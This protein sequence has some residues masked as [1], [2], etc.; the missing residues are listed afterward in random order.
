Y[1]RPPVRLYRVRSTVPRLRFVTRAR[2]LPQGADLAAALS[3]RDYDPRDAVLLED[4]SAG[5]VGPDGGSTG[6]EAVIVDE[7]PESIRMR[8]RAAAPGYAVLADA[9]AP[10]W[11]S[12]LDGRPIDLLRADGL[13]RAVPVPAREHEVTMRYRPA[14][15]TYGLLAGGLGF[16]VACALGLLAAWRGC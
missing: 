11:R 9:W 14:S 7:P 2:P 1:S 13:F 15:V 3:D 6:G 5:G 4:P 10:G 8:V 12:A 16:L